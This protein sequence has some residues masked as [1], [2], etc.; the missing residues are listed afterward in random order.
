[1]GE[2]VETGVAVDGVSEGTAAD[3]GG[4]LAGDVIIGWNGAR[5]DGLEDLFGRLQQHQ[6]G[7]EVEIT[8]L[9]DGRRVTLDVT[10]KASGG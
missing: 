2:D 3:E 6:P 1:M 5:I 7:D 4:M 10:L 9:R 8:V